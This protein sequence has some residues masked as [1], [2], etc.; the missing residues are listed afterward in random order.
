MDELPERDERPDPG[1]VPNVPSTASP[2]EHDNTEADHHVEELSLKSKSFSCINGKGITR[3][4]V[5]PSRPWVLVTTLVGEVILSNYE[6][7]EVILTMQDA[8]HGAIWSADFHPTKTLFVVAPKSAPL[9]LFDYNKNVKVKDFGDKEYI[10]WNVEF[11]PTPSLPWVIVGGNTCKIWNWETEQML[12]V[13]SEFTSQLTSAGWAGAAA[14]RAF[15]VHCKTPPHIICRIPDDSTEKGTEVLFTD[16]AATCITADFRDPKHPL[17]LAGGWADGSLRVFDFSKQA[18]LTAGTVHTTSVVWVK[19]VGH[20]SV[21]SCSQDG[22]FVLWRVVALPCVTDD[23]KLTVAALEQIQTLTVSTGAPL[24]RPVMDATSAAL[25]LT[26]GRRT[27]FLV[28]IDGYSVARQHASPLPPV[29]RTARS[30]FHTRFTSVIVQRWRALRNAAN[31]MSKPS[32]SV[33]VSID[34]EMVG[35]NQSQEQ[36]SPSALTLSGEEELEPTPIP[37]S[38]GPRSTLRSLNFNAFEDI[39][40]FAA[41]SEKELIVLV[42]VSRAFRSHAALLP[43]W[44]RMLP[45]RHFANETPCR[46]Q[47]NHRAIAA[48]L[49]CQSESTGRASVRSVADDDGAPIENLIK[50]TASQYDFLSDPHPYFDIAC[51]DLSSWRYANQ[52][53]RSIVYRSEKSIMNRSL[54]VTIASLL[55]LTQ[56]L[57]LPSCWGRNLRGF[58]IALAEMLCFLLLI[59]LPYCSKWKLNPNA[60]YI[61]A[62]P[63][64]WLYVPLQVAMPLLIGPSI[65]VIMVNSSP[66]TALDVSDPLD[67]FRYSCIT[68]ATYLLVVFACLAWEWKRLPRPSLSALFRQADAAITLRTASWPISAKVLLGILAFVLVLGV[69][70]GY[71]VFQTMVVAGIRSL[72]AV[73]SWIGVG[74]SWLNVGFQLGRWLTSF[75]AYDIADDHQHFRDLC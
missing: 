65:A 24:V 44:D 52:T 71:F 45:L 10:V 37:E 73:G 18:L 26:D 51:N 17:L 70:F 60:A 55:Y 68:L 21:L 25:I 30:S 42:H 8:K 14:P 43:I 39:L 4:K 5:H 13:F 1:V 66:K 61:V 59:L 72:S 11:H 28:K 47:L 64:L 69:W 54:A 27:P 19:V 6:T 2:T 35:L 38:L 62:A 33:V 48:T 22:Q 40:E 12:H 31:L 20:S 15:L 75:P 46:S 67:A 50:D 41:A 34:E 36:Q 49:R 58:Y 3:V 32:D 7:D 23:S 53:A 16:S 56:L 57:F 63:P 74:V 29:D 9:A